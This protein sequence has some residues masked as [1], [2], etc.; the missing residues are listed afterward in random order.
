GILEAALETARGALREV[1]DRRREVRAEL[2]AQAER[3][4]RA[5]RLREDLVRQLEGTR[6]ARERAGSRAVEARRE[7]EGLRSEEEGLV[8][9]RR[10]A[11]EALEVAQEEW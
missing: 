9:A 3:R 5:D 4:L 7:R 10:L 11:R 2:Q 8:D 1:E 6:M